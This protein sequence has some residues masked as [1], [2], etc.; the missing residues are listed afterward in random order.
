MK[1]KLCTH[2]M[3]LSICIELPLLATCTFQKGI[4]RMCIFSYKWANL[5][6]PINV[7]LTYCN[8]IVTLDLTDAV[9]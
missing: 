1:P 7:L 8:F 3:W 5:S 9:S 4:Y 2:C 6:L